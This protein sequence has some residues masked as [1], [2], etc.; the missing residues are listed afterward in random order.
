M[1]PHKLPE[2][3]SIQELAHF[4][5]SHDLTDFEDDLEVVAAPVFERPRM[6]TIRLESDEAN[7]VSRIAESK[8]MA[9]VDLIR[10]WVV[11]RISHP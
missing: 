7:A 4:W 11:E 3:D 8:G 5:D 1:K 6:V 10:Q 9:D 2:T